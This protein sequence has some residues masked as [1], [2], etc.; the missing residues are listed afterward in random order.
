M[1]D[2]LMVKLTECCFFLLF[3]F[4]NFTKKFKTSTPQFI[5]EKKGP[6]Y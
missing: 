5:S 3:I 1:T 4:L 2:T 6:L